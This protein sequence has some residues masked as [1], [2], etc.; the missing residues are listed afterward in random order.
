MI[1]NS[2][3]AIRLDPVNVSGYGGPARVL[4]A[5]TAML[6]KTDP[7]HPGIPAVDNVGRVFDFHGLRHQFIS[8]LAVAS[9]PKASQMLARHSTITLTMDL[10]THLGLVDQTAVLDTLPTLLNQGGNAHQAMKATGTDGALTPR[11]PFSCRHDDETSGNM[12]KSDGRSLTGR[13][14]R[15]EAQSLAIVGH[16]DPCGRKMKLDDTRGPR[17]G[18]ADTGDLKS[19]GG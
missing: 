13:R 1:E 2:E 9:H 4:A 11:L 10:Y 14:S 16:G 8:N 12:E 5:V 7:E 18:M 3:E 17:G 19:P 15:G 6:R